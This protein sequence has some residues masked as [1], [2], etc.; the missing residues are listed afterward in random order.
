MALMADAVRDFS[1]GF[2]ERYNT[3]EVTNNV[4]IYGG[5]AVSEAADG[6]AEPLVAA[7]PFLGFAEGRIDTTP[8]N[9]AAGDLEVRLRE[10][11]EVALI[12]AGITALTDLNSPVYASDDNTFTLTALGN[13][14]IGAIK[15]IV[16]VTSGLCIVAFQSE[17]LRAA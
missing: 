8:A 7:S 12:V 9:I 15:R 16:D 2:F 14:Q 6:R 11:G 3:I 10:E 4:I 13:T 17:A 1:V 5:A